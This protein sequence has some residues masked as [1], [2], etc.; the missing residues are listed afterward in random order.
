MAARAF[1]T[2]SSCFGGRRSHSA[3]RDSTGT[4]A[5]DPPHERQAGPRA[6]SRPGGQRLEAPGRWE[7]PPGAPAARRDPRCARRASEQHRASR[8][9]LG[10]PLPARDAPQPGAGI[11]ARSRG[12]LSAGP[13]AP[14]GRSFRPA[15]IPAQG[16]VLKLERL[17][18]LCGAQCPGVAAVGKQASAHTPVRGGEERASPPF[19]RLCGITRSS[20]WG[21]GTERTQLGQ[22]MREDDSQLNEPSIQGRG[23][24]EARRPSPASSF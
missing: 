10:R 12:V 1:F 20:V 23:P 2:P 13:W 21:R 4:P 8:R 9:C 6:G 19:P 18:L 16:Q 11:G 24:G 7:T 5:P 22:G 3:S 17:P 15:P 14:G